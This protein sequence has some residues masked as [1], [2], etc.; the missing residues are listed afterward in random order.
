[1]RYLKS[2]MF[3]SGAILLASS[4]IALRPSF[5]ADLRGFP[6]ESW[7]VYAPMQLSLLAVGGALAGIA[8]LTASS[9]RLKSAK[10]PNSPTTK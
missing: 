4:V 9:I 1:M 6:N 3:I 8:L 2:P 5:H 7:N 10:R